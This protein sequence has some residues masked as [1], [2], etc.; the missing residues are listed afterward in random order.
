MKPISASIAVLLA[1]CLL[2][3]AY[4]NQ[5]SAPADAPEA[6]ASVASGT[7]TATL[8]FMSN[9]STFTNTEFKNQ[10]QIPVQKKFPNIKIELIE[11]QRLH[12]LNRR[13]ELR[14]RLLLEG[15]RLTL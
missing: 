6:A 3:S 1:G 9:G 12:S 4:S 15:I 5:Q 13:D 8:R 10:I 2:L 14:S 7:E 11:P